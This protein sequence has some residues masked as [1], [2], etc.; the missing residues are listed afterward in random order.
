MTVI[1]QKQNDVVILADSKKNYVAALKGTVIINNGTGNSTVNLSFN[2]TNGFTGNFTNGNLTINLQ[3]ANATQSGKLT[4]SDWQRLDG[5]VGNVTLAQ[6]NITALQNETASINNTVNLTSGNVTVLQNLTA[7][8]NQTLSNHTG[9]FTN[10]HNVT[11]SQIGLG[12][13]SDIAPLDLPI[14]NATQAALNN[15]LDASLYVQHY[16]GVYANLTAL[17]TACPT[18]IAGD[19]AQIDAGA[20]SN[21]E[22]WAYDLQEGWIKISST[23]SGALNTD[24]LPEGS[25]NFYFTN[26]RAIAA[27]LTGFTAGAGNI[28]ASDSILQSIQKLSGNLSTKAEQSELSNYAPLNRTINGVNLSANVTLTTANITDSTDKRYVNESQ[29]ASINNITSNH[30]SL[31]NLEWT[32]SGHTGTNSTLAGF[33]ANGNATVY[34]LSGDGSLILTNNASNL[35]TPIS[36]NLTNCNGNASALTA[37]NVTNIPN[38][39]GAITSNNT[40]TSLGSFTSSQLA[41][42]LSDETGTGSAVFANNAT[43]NSPNLTTPSYLNATNAVGNATN[44]IVG[45]VSNLNLSGNGTNI[46]GNLN[47]TLGGT[48]VSSGL[49]LTR[50]RVRTETGNYT[51]TTS[52][53][54]NDNTK[55][56]ITEG[57]EVLNV[58]ITPINAN[59]TLKI[60]ALIHAANNVSLSTM[61]CAVFAS[62]STDAL[63]ASQVIP[64]QANATHPIPINAEVVLNTTNT[65]YITARIGTG[66]GITTYINGAAGAQ[67]LGGAMISSITVEEMTA[68]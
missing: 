30:S 23:G 9:N 10:P 58:A 40:V 3:N 1:V 43:L 53:I 32:Q 26:N 44:L 31:T 16:K 41:T 55:P 20:G 18:G 57:F 49:V 28:T 13:V 60:N 5:A 65:T 24:G 68:G 29:L 56:Q 52:T 37:G 14:N 39:T 25:T 6:S 2:E 21:A 42:A 22:L 51:S 34:S 19:H 11:K 50:Q 17:Q 38:L 54:P 47:V 36:G 7:S 8:I 63:A 4:S 46:T 64:T 27:P 48:G 62:S 61:T 35:G 67:K 12:N 66:S 59:S 15:K 45:N 33:T